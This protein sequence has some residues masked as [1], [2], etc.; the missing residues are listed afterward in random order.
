MSQYILPS[1]QID[2]TIQQ[3][4]FS[5]EEN[6]QKSVTAYLQE[7][8]SQLFDLEQ[9]PLMRASLIKLKDQEHVFFLSLHHN[10]W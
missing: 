10:Y 8:N 2:F 3:E 7:I 1:D 9:A 5:L 6:Q 4:N